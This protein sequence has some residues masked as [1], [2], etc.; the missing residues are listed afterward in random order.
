MDVEVA[1]AVRVVLG[2]IQRSGASRVQLL[3][4]RVHV[5]DEHIDGAMARLPLRLAGRLEVND[6]AVSFDSRVER[7]LA[8]RELG[9]KPEHVTVVLDASEHILLYE[10]LRQRKSV[11]RAI[12]R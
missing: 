7:R 12:Q 5:G 4:Q 9:V 6:H 1:H 8:I 10:A 2:L 3:I 11:P